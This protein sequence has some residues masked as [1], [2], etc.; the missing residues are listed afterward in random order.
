MVQVESEYVKQGREFLER[1]GIEFRAV[2]IG[3]D[4]PKFCSDALKQI[5]MDKVDTFPRKTHIHGKHYRCTFSCK[6]RGHISI[7]F[8]NSYSDAEFNW[9]R[10]NAHDLSYQAL[11]RIF[12]KRGYSDGSLGVLP[13]KNKEREVTAYDVICCLTKDDPGTFEQF[14]GDF[15]YDE[16]SRRAE[17]TY[18]AVVD[19]WKRVRRFF[20]DV[21]LTEVREIQ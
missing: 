1:N 11:D 19:E 7:D 2:M 15:G 17:E 10:K 8:W 12:G 3:N 21:E 20:T 14:C 18:R 16:D 5:D 13:L 6:G 4:C 9:A